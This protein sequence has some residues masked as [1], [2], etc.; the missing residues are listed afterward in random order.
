MFFNVNGFFPPL[1]SPSCPEKKHS[2]TFLV[3]VTKP[4]S[5][6]LRYSF[7]HS[8]FH[9]VSMLEYLSVYPVCAQSSSA[10]LCLCSSPCYSRSDTSSLHSLQQNCT[11]ITEVVPLAALAHYQDGPLW[12]AENILYLSLRWGSQSQLPSIQKLFSHISAFSHY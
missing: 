9:P 5:I 11:L 8:F 1:S 3:I 12:T 2:Q 10:G 6:S 7:P 4:L